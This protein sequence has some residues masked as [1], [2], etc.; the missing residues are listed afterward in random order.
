MNA[1][2]EKLLDFVDS[3]ERTSLRNCFE[4]IQE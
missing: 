2:L 1:K 4:L 3:L